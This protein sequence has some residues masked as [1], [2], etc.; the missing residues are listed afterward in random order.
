MRYYLMNKNRKMLEFNI[1]ISPLGES[2]NT[3][4]VFTDKFPKGFN[5]I[6]TWLNNRNYA[7]HKQHFKKWLSEWGI[8]TIQGF[9]DITH[10]LGINDC[11]WVKNID[12]DLK[13]EEINLYSNQ[14]SD[15][16]QQ[17]AFDSGLYGLK[18]SS[19]D[20]ISPEFTSEGT[21]PKCWKNENGTIFLYKSKLSGAIN[22]GLEANCE[23]I[24]SEIAR[25]IVGEESIKYDLVMFKDKLCSKS[26]LFTSEKYGYI[27][28]Y[29]YID[30][31]RYY[32]LSD[33]LRICTEMGY[34]NECRKMIL[35]DSIT[36]NQD[37]HLGNFGFLVD[38]DTFEIKS[39]A[40]LFDYNSSMLCNALDEDI[41]NL[42]AFHKYEDEYMLGHKLGGKFFEIG[43]AILTPEL[44]ELIPKNIDFPIHEKYNLQTDRINH[45]TDILQENIQLIT[46]RTYYQIKSLNIQPQLCKS[47]DNLQ[48]EGDDKK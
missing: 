30:T 3:E 15:I 12:S 46:G 37:R 29:K 28:F 25:K 22:F 26:Q 7:K 13:W 16:A 24:S 17:T 41:Q 20:I 1:E 36:F 47:R 4:R 19:T 45:L 2:I 9:I 39:F 23:Y 32:N 44:L 38:N 14:F 27:P 8:D 5:D 11:L 42:D 21:A 34:E 48:K 10:G 40:P 43:S 18:L 31:N 6:S 33:V 35:I